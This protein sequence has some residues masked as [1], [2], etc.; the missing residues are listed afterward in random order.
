M[1]KNRVLMTWRSFQVRRREEAILDEIFST[2]L[3]VWAI[4][5]KEYDLKPTSARFQQDE[6]HALMQ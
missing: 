3:G 4:V 2:P 1:S 6:E 5:G